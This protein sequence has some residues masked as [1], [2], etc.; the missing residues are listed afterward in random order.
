M[1]AINFFVSLYHS[2]FMQ[3]ILKNLKFPVFTLLL[4]LLVLILS[5]TFFYLLQQNI[6]QSEIHRLLACPDAFFIFQGE[7]W[8]IVTNSFVHNNLAMLILNL[9]GLWILSAF[10][11]RRSGWKAVFFLGLLASMTTSLTQLALS[12]DPGIGMSGVNYFFLGYIFM[13]SRQDPR[14]HFS[15]KYLALLLAIAG[16]VLIVIGNAQFN[17][18]IGFESIVS[19]LIYGL[20]FA[21]IKKRTVRLYFSVVSV[22]ISIIVLIYSPW[23]AMWNFSKAFNAHNSGDLYS[24]ETFY[25]RS[26]GLNPSLED[27]RLNLNLI[28]I[29]RLS[30]EAFKLHN[31]GKYMKARQKYE[32][33]L[34][35]DPTNKWANQQ[36]RLLP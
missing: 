1:E 21:L 31:A 29:D 26:L 12:D 5:S 18:N 35:I 2:E 6:P 19:G 3:I 34:E 30:S 17:L 10:I 36:I 14:Y 7:F 15:L 24:A 20:L 4:N 22:L 11:E 23:S 27:A 16:P 8:G 32:A 33:I 28:K 25:A 9:S 13:R